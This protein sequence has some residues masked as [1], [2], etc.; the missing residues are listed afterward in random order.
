[1]AIA[2]AIGGGFLIS[3]VMSLKGVGLESFMGYSSTFVMVIY[4]FSL[5]CDFSFYDLVNN[6]NKIDYGK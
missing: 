4:S 2:F 6:K 3:F 5:A 1:M